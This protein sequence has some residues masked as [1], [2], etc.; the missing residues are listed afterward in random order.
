MKLFV[1]L[2]GSYTIVTSAFA[3]DLS[4]L[5]NCVVDV[6][7]NTARPNDYQPLFTNNYQSLM[8][9]LQAQNV[10][11]SFPALYQKSMLDPFINFLYGLGAANFQQIFFS[12]QPTP[13]N[14]FFKEI[15]PD[16]TEAI[17]QNGSMV[18]A[19]A[20]NAFQEMVSDLYDGFLSD[21]SRVSNQTGMPIKPP[22][23][24]IIPPLVKWGNPQNGPY[25]WPI[26]ATI[27]VG[28]G[29]SVVSLPPNNRL[30]GLFAW[31]TLPHETAGHDILHADTGLLTELGNLVYNAVMVN[32]NNNAFL[33][34]YWKQCIDETASDIL[35][36][37]NGGPA[38]G[39]GL[40][41]YFRGLM[42]GALISYGY[43]PPADT[44]PIAILR[45]YMAARAVA[46]MPF[47]GAQM[48]ADAIRAEV[49]KDLKPIYLIV[50]QTGQQIPLDQQTVIWSAEIIT[51][52][53]INSKLNSLEGHSLSEIQNWS[54]QD[55]AIAE[56]LGILLRTGSPLPV[57][58]RNSGFM[59]AHVVAGATY[60]ALKANADIAGL[61]TRMI[62]FL[63]IMHQNN[64]TWNANSPPPPVPPPPTPVPPPSPVD[65]QCFYQCLQ[66]CNRQLNPV[67][68]APHLSTSAI[69]MEMAE[70]AEMAIGE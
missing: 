49:S 62:D 7:Q 29:A 39:I 51:D 48:W 43:M 52:T 27:G 40:V 58:Y 26:D 65:C 67:V 8:M 69:P 44:H 16:V 18:A 19:K 50:P 63:D 37:L 24:G 33:A 36:H 61:F 22:D 60:E 41:G 38:I 13:Q 3:V 20:T 23:K 45:G 6:Q 47:P 68:H 32:L 59:A 12:P 21:E 31:T 66:M 5:N 1:T 46:Q 54:A 25:T 14:A 56:N 57:D 55:Q 42:G 9:T 30:G 2:L 10:R 64:A 35:G 15:I 11:A 53:I 17:L 34:N 4:N 70:I 28:V